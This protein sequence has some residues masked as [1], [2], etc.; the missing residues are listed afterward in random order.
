MMVF[1]RL[2]DL[3]G[4]IAL[5]L[6]AGMAPVQ[7]ADVV[8]TKNIGL[9]LANQIAMASVEACRKDVIRSAPWWSIATAIYVPPCAMI[10]RR[11]LHCKSL[12][13]KRI[14]W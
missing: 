5:G 7:A 11:D 1:K 6:F 2:A 10:W 4:W 13:K 12:R 8:T 3:G 14:W 9:E